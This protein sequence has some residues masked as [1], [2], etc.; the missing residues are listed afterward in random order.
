MEVTAK[1]S[2]PESAP[3][4]TRW[5]RFSL[6]AIGLALT[7]LIVIVINVLG[8]RFST[9]LD[10]TRTGAL[11]LS[12][13]TE[14]VIES[15]PGESEVILAGN[16]SA[17]GRDRAAMSRVLDMIDELDASSPNVRTTVINTGTPT[18]VGEYEALLARL[19]EERSAETQDAVSSAQS[20]MAALEQLGQAMETWAAPVQDL[21]NQHVSAPQGQSPWTGELL[22]LGAYLSTSAGQ[23]GQVRSLVDQH[24]SQTMGETPV[25]D[26]GA[27]KRV[28]LDAFGALTQIVQ[29]QIEY[30]ATKAQD[31]AMSAEGARTANALARQMQSAL[32]DTALS[33]DAFASRELPVLSRVA[34]ALASAEA[35]L[36]IGPDGTE[37]TAIPIDEIAPTNVPGQARI[38]AGRRAET[39][40]GSAIAATSG[41]ASETTVV[42]IHGTDSR[43]LSERSPIQQLLRAMAIRG[44]RWVEWPVYLSPE[45]PAEVALAAQKPGTVYVVIGMSMTSEGGTERAIR[46]GGVLTDL[47]ES[48][49]NV[50]VALSPSTMQGQGEEDPMAKPLE[51]FGLSADSGRPTLKENLIADRRFVEWEQLIIPDETGHPLAEVIR[52]LPTRLTWP[53]AIDRTEDVGRAWPLLRAEGDDIW[54]EAEW[55]S[56]WLEKDVNRHSI[57]NPPAPGGPRDAEVGEGAYAWAA[58]R[59]VDGQTQRLIAVG[60]HLWLF[61]MI[62]R[63]TAEIEGTLVETSQGNTEL[64]LAGV[65]WLAGQDA[66]IARS[67]EAESFPIIQ[68]MSDSRMAAARW[69]F[70]GGLPLLVLIAGVIVRL[71]GG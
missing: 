6:T 63:R 57:A 55:L 60:S 53:I 67:A 52:K 64:A 44:I 23:V 58:E 45:Q 37:L 31:P 51:A 36:V 8:S 20:A 22:Q 5:S 19:S 65:Q 69:F 25:P 17:P 54:R 18:G 16:L 48:G 28:I 24:L 12:E 43:I 56:Y 9:R 2:T 1:A 33:V 32:D 70:M 29:T 49:E 38:D 27:A 42:L 40:I 62:A 3:A 46:V 41:N 4:H 30:L 47:I 68:P 21:A 26:V 15:L 61:D 34:G 11:T 7:I 14:R 50:L 39:L 10:V 35:V 59:E 13:R 66:S 71:V